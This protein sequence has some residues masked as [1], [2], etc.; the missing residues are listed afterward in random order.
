MDKRWFGILVILIAGIACMYLIVDSST[1]VG[2]AVTVADE[3]TITLPSGFNL[4]K[5]KDN[6]VSLLDH[7][8][9][10][11]NITIMGVGDKALKEFNSTLKS[12]EEDSDIEIKDTKQNSTANIIYYKNLTTDK[13][14]TMTYF[15][16]DNRTIELKMDK[17][18]NWE[19]DWN[20]IV[21]TIQHN[22][23]QNK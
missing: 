2:K 20:F 18:K 8:N 11:A 15:V 10:T 23:K 22:F 7:Q 6:F 5:N 12:F 1:T 14:Y 4:L 9:H 13:K 21:D 3:M 17:Y 19:D 16:K